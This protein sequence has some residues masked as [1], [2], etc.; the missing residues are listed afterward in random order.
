MTNG[1]PCGIATA[2]VA[3]DID[4]DDD[5]D[6]IAGFYLLATRASDKDCR[7][8]VLLYNFETVP[9][10]VRSAFLVLSQNNKLFSNG[11]WRRS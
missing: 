1:V 2:A 10:N 8:L 5:E 9:S 3:A 6:T 11:R 4:D 7:S